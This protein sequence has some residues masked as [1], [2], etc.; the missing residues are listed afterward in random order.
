MGLL[1]LPGLWLP[2][3]LASGGG[4]AS[5]VRQA[6]GSPRAAVLRGGGGKGLGPQRVVAPVCHPSLPKPPPI[7]LFPVHRFS[8]SL[9]HHRVDLFFSW[10]CSR[11]G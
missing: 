2:Q 5:K 8:P 10:P 1:V 7:S 6:A 11:W 9:S 4:S 3:P